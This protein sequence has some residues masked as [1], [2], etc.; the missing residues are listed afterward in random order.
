MFVSEN[1]SSQLYV[2]EQ[3]WW[4][5]L[6]SSGLYEKTF[7][8]MEVAFNLRFASAF[9]GM[10]DS[11]K[12]CFYLLSGLLLWAV[13]IIAFIALLVRLVVILSVRV[14]CSLYEAMGRSNLL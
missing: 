13:K 7:V 12:G 6:L 10:T 4:L 14:T 2:G 1:S 3:R 11:K 9:K 5:V 8:E